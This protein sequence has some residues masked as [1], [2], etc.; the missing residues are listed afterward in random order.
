MEWNA[1]DLDLVIV[2]CIQIFVSH[3]PLILYEQVLCAPT[4]ALLGSVCHQI[5]DAY[6]LWEACYCSW[7]PTSGGC[8]NE[9]LAHFTIGIKST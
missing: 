5:V 2:H 6:T 1:S 4:L 8:V 7:L 3:I 9:M